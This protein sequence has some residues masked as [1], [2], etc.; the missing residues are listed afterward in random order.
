MQLQRH[1]L[2]LTRLQ[3]DFIKTNVIYILGSFQK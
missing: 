1:M 2:P 3:Q